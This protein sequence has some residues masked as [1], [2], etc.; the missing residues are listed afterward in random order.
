[1]IVPYLDLHSQ[2]LSIKNEI[3]NSIKEIIKN[4]SFILGDAVSEFETEFASKC[5]VN[6][7]ISTANGTDSIYIILKS[8]GIGLGDEVITVANSWISSSETISQTGAKPVFVD[9]DPDY[10]SIN[11]NLIKE[12]ITKKTKAIIIVHL[13]GQMC[14][15]K[16][17]LKIVESNNIFLIED[18]AQSHF[19]EFNNKKA[20]TFGIAGSFSFYPGKNLGAFGD[21]GAIISNDNEF[22]K[23]CK[24]FARHGALVKHEHVIEGINSRMDGIQANVLNVKLKYILKWTDERIKV[25]EFY[26]ENLKSVS[27]ISLPRIRKNTKHSFHLYVI[28]VKKR[29]ELIEFLKKHGIQTAIHYPTPLPFLKAYN[30]LNYKKEDFPVS[31]DYQNKILSLPIYPELS[32]NKINFVCEK[33]KEFYE[34]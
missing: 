7:C 8:L 34:I 4:S 24:M 30:Y 13:Q 2:Y 31:H 6:H 16:E 28:R 9:I 20:G 17:I 12:K 29:K 14:N 33:I 25:A 5:N 22:A 10:Y 26:S 15:M 23:K 21:A 1:M 11:E 3:D 32:L 27:Q 19:S 18:C